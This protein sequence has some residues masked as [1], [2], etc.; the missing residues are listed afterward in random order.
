MSL[1]V[2]GAIDIT[3]VLLL[4]LAILPALGQQTAALRHTVLAAALASA[5]MVA[6]I[7]PVLPEW[8]LPVRISAPATADALLGTGREMPMPGVRSPQPEEIASSS[9]R[10]TELLTVFLRVWAL[11]AI[12]GMAALLFGFARLRH[13]ART[14]RRMTDR[15]WRAHVD[16][17]SD[18]LG[19]S[20]P[21]LLL[22]SR[23]PHLLVVWGVWRPRVLLPSVA[24]DW[25]DARVR[26]VLT[27]ELAHVRRGD[28]V[29]QCLAEL[30]RAVYWFN[31]VVWKACARLRRESDQACDDMV[32]SAGVDGPEYAAHLVDIARVLRRQRAWT[33]ALAMAH[34][35]G[36]E[37]RIQAML[38]T[39]LN[40]R[41]LSRWTHALTVVGCLSLA[42]PLAA[43]TAVQAAL[44]TF[45]GSVLDPSNAVLPNTVVTLTNPETLAKYEVRTDRDGRYEIPGLPVGRYVLESNVPGFK[46]VRLEL[47]VGGENVQKDLKLELGTL[48]E[49]ITIA[50]GRNVAPPKQMTAE[51]RA[52]FD[53]RVRTRAEQRCPD[54]PRTAPAIGGNIRTPVKLRD[55]RPIYPAE[56]ASAGV[57]GTVV[58]LAVIDTNGQVNDVNVESATHSEFAAAAI[59]AVKQ[60]EFDA[61]LLNC[62]PVE[63]WMTVT[64]SFVQR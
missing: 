38:N 44:V 28:W 8:S 7:Q 56:L 53:E 46:A 48:Q 49:T 51:E 35:S 15:R 37:R 27:H 5:A 42:V 12:V 14:A 10:S 30:M 52:K 20:R 25:P 40:R 45:T 59:D 41:P 24:R 23:D 4:A 3:L 22:E 47:A 55:R 36:F 33:P 54:S 17:I 29:V 18:E 50:T 19:L 31:P 43:L 1:L 58:L 39:Q 32:L 26:L 9:A 64:A 60:W 11:G 62:V 34:T 61:T 57:S 6:A 2:E 21:V 13:L 63:T 16:A